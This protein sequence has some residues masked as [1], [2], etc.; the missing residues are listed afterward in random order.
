M[1][2]V[3]LQP[4]LEG[5]NNDEE[6]VGKHMRCASHIR[7]LVKTTDADK[8]LNKYAIYK[9]YYRLAFAKAQERCGIN[10]PEAARRRM[11]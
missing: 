6:G 11:S 5:D 3:Q 10:S 1:Q 9:K 8:T 4:I 7:N 2:P